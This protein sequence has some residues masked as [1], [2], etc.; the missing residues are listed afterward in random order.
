ML[1]NARADTLV[2]SGLALA[3]NLAGLVALPVCNLDPKIGRVCL[4]T[5]TD[6]WVVMSSGNPGCLNDIQSSKMCM[7][8]DTQPQS[9]QGGCGSR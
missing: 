2:V 5:I 7:E 4:A 1:F 6:T 9:Q 3:D 8:P